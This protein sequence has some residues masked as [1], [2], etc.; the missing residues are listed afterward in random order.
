[1]GNGRKGYRQSIIPFPFSAKS[2]CKL[3]DL[4]EDV[5]VTGESNSG[6]W[7]NLA[8][9]LAVLA[10]RLRRSTVQVRGRRAGAGSGVIWSANGTIVTNAHVVR[11][12]GAIVELVDGRT[13]NANVVAKDAQRDLALLK[14]DAIDLPAVAVGDSNQLRVGEL[15]FAV[16]NPLGMVGALTTG[17]VHATPTATIQ[18]GW[19]QADIP[20]APGNS[21]G[22]L[23]DGQGRVIGINSM[24][25]NG[26]AFAV[27]SHDVQV[28]L[29]QRD[30]RPRLGITLQP[31]TVPVTGTKVAGWLVLEVA[32]DSLAAQV[33]LLTGDILIGVGSNFFKTPHD[34]T[35]ML[36]RTQLGVPL[37]LNFIRGGEF[38]TCAVILPCPDPEVRAA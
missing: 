1:M 15:V 37:Q 11:G 23:A 28:F 29:E 18:P 21:G 31:V 35:W 20:L 16:G 17:I 25:V 34:L 14:I 5:M 12:T 30:D 36:S 10:E 6:R 8:D 19:I 4:N 13:F 24:I 2:L 26:L 3:L 32:T 27:P 38:K 9:E 33:G 7:Q 22:L